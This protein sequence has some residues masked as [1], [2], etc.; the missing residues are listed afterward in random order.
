M[1]VNKNE[2]DEQTQEEYDHMMNQASI[3]GQTQQNSTQAAQYYMQEQ[4]KGLVD[5]QLEVDSIKLDV[6]HL[7]RQDLMTRNDETGESNWK[8]LANQEER[9]LSDWGVDRIMQVIHFYVNKN[10]LLSNFSED[11]INRLMLRFVCELNDLVLLKYQVLFRQASFEECKRIIEKRIADKEKMIVFRLEILGKEI[12]KKKIHD[13]LFE[14]IE[15]VLEKEID[16]IREEQRKEKLRD[17]GILMAQIEAIIYS[18]FNRAWKGEERGSIRRHTNISELIG[19]RQ[20][21]PKARGGIFS[22]GK[23]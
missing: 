14:K 7:I 4:E 1:G 19:G 18:T 20:M 12:N 13:D 11:Q 5:V 9:T 17:Y 15:T 16:K 6:Y 3:M 10:T 22:W 21:Q 2:M 8:Q 23:S